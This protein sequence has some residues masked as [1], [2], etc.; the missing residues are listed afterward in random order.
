M[1]FK[2]QYISTDTIFYIC[3]GSTLVGISIDS[4]IHQKILT[5]VT[6]FTVAMVVTMFI[7]RFRTRLSNTQLLH[8]KHTLT[9]D[10]GHE[11]EQSTRYKYF[12]EAIIQGQE[13]EK[14]RLA[15]ELHDDTIQR[16]IIIGQRV[17]LAN[18]DLNKDGQYED[19][20]NI[21]N[22]I[23]ESIHSI[24]LFIK[25][26]RPMYLDKLGLVPT[27]EELV[28]QS[29]KHSDSNVN[30]T[31]E[32][33]G[34]PARLDN[35]VELALYRIAQSAVTNAI[36]HSSGNT[37]ELKI[38]FLN[39]TIDLSIIDNGKGFEIPDEMS[40][41]QNTSF[42]LM[43]MQERADFIGAEFSVHTAATRGTKILIRVPATN[44][45]QIAESND[46][47]TVPHLGKTS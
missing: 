36:R 33:S 35:Q 13:Q 8:E 29:N 3:F 42:G 12:A 27:L 43:G 38:T 26:L 14:K 32:C 9:K 11:K 2:K 19:M 20:T 10:L 7:H 23:N 41:L 28:S 44:K 4:F 1:G 34:E 24:R 46:S 16:L 45:V 5:M 21:E 31:F 40:L 37:I 17:Q 15:Q 39:H 25:Q 6:P 18:M 30:I 47:I 22:L